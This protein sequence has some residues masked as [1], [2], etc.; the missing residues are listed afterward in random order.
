MSNK[1]LVTGGAGFIGSHLCEKL[2]E[3]LSNKIYSFDNYSTG[4]KT[5]H[6]KG[7]HYINGHTKDINNLID[8]K[9]DII[10]HLGEYSRV[11]QSFDDLDTV[12]K[13]NV[14]GT[15]EVLKFCKNNSCRLIYAGSSTKFG[16]GGAGKNQS[17]YGW[18]KA[19]NTELIKNFSNWYSLNY[20]IVYFYNA[21]GPR[22]I[23]DGKY[24]TLIA[25]FCKQMAEDKP[26]TIVSP[27]NQVRN[28][29][30]VYDIISGLIIVGKNGFGDN[31]G[32]GNPQ[33][34]SVIQ[35]A[36][37]FGGKI[38]M[39]PERQGN[40]MS[41]QVHAEKTIELGWKPKYEI[42]DYVDQIRRN[43]WEL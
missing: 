16:D 23:R 35:I 32:I 20:A 3:D 37:I 1:I 24:S 9:V 27:G 6:I 2:A 26:L 33:S 18:T 29:T 10:F 12:Y 8:F 43:N 7:V 34:Y 4:S 41:A 40:R 38:K 25:K 30:H 5:N 13:S 11:E 31:Y 15:F 28:F 21:Y 39:L 14:I 19:S 17:P 22:E 36:K 42:I